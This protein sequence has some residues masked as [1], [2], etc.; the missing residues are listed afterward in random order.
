M[1]IFPSQKKKKTKKKK[2]FWGVL[3][4]AEGQGPQYDFGGVSTFVV[5]QSHFGIDPHCSDQH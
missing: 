3:K 5:P 1:N 2:V 4:L